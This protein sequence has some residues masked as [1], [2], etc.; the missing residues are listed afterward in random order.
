MSTTTPIPASLVGHVPTIMWQSVDWTG[1]TLVRPRDGDMRVVLPVRIEGGGEPFDITDD[2]KKGG[3]TLAQ[4]VGMT[5][6]NPVDQSTQGIQGDGS[7]VLIVN[8][9]NPFKAT[10][11]Q[12]IISD[13]GGMREIRSIEQYRALIRKIGSRAGSPDIYN[14]DLAWLQKNTVQQ[15][16]LLDD[17]LTFKDGEHYFGFLPK[18]GEFSSA[19]YVSAEVGFIGSRG[20]D[21]SLI[22]PV[23]VLVKGAAMIKVNADGQPDPTGEQEIP[24]IYASQISPFV[25]AYVLAD[26]TE[27]TH[28]NLAE[29]IAHLQYSIE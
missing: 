18:T 19:Y 29:V 12:E 25:G 7:G 24:D 22:A 10:Q 20:Q 11:I 6:T 15:P 3:W 17:A 4:G 28:A 14:S 23:G 21:H 8:G 16:D 5:F 27:I 26:G 9:V 2:P 1:A 13:M